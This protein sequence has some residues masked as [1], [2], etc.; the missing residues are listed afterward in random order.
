MTVTCNYTR[1]LDT[2]TGTLAPACSTHRHYLPCPHDGEPPLADAPV[3]LF[4]NGSSR[5]GALAY[6]RKA[7]GRARDIVLHN[8]ADGDRDHD[9][10]ES[11]ACWC[12]PEVT[13]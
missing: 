10:G 4:Q 2:D 9:A 1:V 11:T 5:E 3:H 12:G 7:T 13:R 8:E 6:A